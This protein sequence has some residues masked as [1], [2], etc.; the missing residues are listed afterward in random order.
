MLC[1]FVQGKTSFVRSLS[2]LGC[3]IPFFSVL[4]GLEETGHAISKPL[5][6]SFF[7]SFPFVAVFLFICF[8]SRYL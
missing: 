4:K 3:D 5:T 1:I 6:L 8:N 2:G 7:V